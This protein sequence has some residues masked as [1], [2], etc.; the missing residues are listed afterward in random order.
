MDAAVLHRRTNM[1]HECVPPDLVDRLLALGHTE[2]ARGL[3]VAQDEDW[4]CARAWA[5]LLAGRGELDEALQVLAPYV[6]TGWWTAAAEA[7]RLL[8][9]GGRGDEAVAEATAHP[10]GGRPYARE[11][12]ALLLAGEGRPEEAVALLDADRLEQQWALGPLLV[13]LG[14][15][16][17]AVTLLRTPRPQVPPP[18][19]TGY[20]DRPP[21]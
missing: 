17:E 8:D 19:P 12:L 20:S 15:V 9:T 7:A 2:V 18:Q 14:R 4:F 11:G 5:R 13:E 10:E 21:F 1:H 16:E 3:A 6:G